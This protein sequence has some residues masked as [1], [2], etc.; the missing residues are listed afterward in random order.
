MELT[1]FHQI[2]GDDSQWSEEQ[3]K[4]AYFLNRM[5]WEGGLTSLLAY[6][7]N[8]FPAE[9]KAQAEFVATAIEDLSKEVIRWAN[10]RG[11]SY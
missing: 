10:E 5:D 4:A 9:L 11:V 7:T 1:P 8:I 3:V 6:G 2:T